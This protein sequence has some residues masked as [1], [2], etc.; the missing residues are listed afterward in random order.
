MI[1]SFSRPRSPTATTDEQSV[2]V[3]YVAWT[4]GRNTR[5]LITL[6][7]NFGRVKTWE[8][9]SKPGCHPCAVITFAAEAE[10]AAAAAALVKLGMQ[11][12]AG[13]PRFYPSFT[14]IPVVPKA[15]M[16]LRPVPTPE[17]QEVVVHLA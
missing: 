8:V 16:S 12:N 2:P 10:A 3:L 7:S 4:D 17:W 15:H 11:G 6:L 14:E 9:L 5:S 13:I 1:F